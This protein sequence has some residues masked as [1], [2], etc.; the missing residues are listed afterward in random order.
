MKIF[1]R[2]QNILLL[3]VIILGFANT[4]S[5]ASFNINVSQDTFKIG[6]QFNVDIKID[7]EDVGINAGQATIKFSPAVLEVVSVDKTSSVFNF[8]IQDVK[9]DNTL[10]EVSFIGGSSSGLI[11]KTLQVVRLVVKAKGLGQSDFVFTDGA[12]TASDGSGTNVLSAMNKATVTIASTSATG[13]TVQ[14]IERTPIT[15]DTVPAKP[16][17]SIPLY[18]DPSKWYNVSSKFTASWKL[19]STV[20]AVATLLNKNS[21]YDPTVSEGIYENESFSAISDGVWY[22]HVRFYNN[23]GWSTT[24]HYRIAIDT[25][26]PSAFVVDFADG[27]TTSDNPTP[28]I[29]YKAGDQLSGISLYHIQVDSDAVI[30][31]DLETSTLPA[32]IPG[33]HT[34]KVTAEDKAGNKVESSAQFEILPIESP[35]IF[36]ASS[37]VYVGEGELVVNGTSLAN[38]SIILDIKDQKG[39]LMY[40][41]ASRADDNGSWAMKIDSPLKKGTYYIEASSMDSRGALS[42]PVKSDIVS[43]VERPIMVIWGFNITYLELIIFLLLIVIIGYTVGWYSRKMISG[44]RSRK[45]L[46]SQRDV[47]SSFN[48]LKKDIEKIIKSWDDGKVEEHE[49]TEIEFNLRHISENLE[50]LQKYIISGIKDIDQK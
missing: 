5:A 43:V 38:V 19:P 42:L 16:V 32:Q 9:Y 25:V 24:N 11:G 23:M 49:I 48:I 27:L 31:T 6:D 21:A 45:I 30:D 14:T 17:V 2:K 35:K 36:S 34:V 33:Q 3:A 20:N 10:G 50:K 39:N 46:I 13:S 18:P 12:I 1:L 4:V 41:F 15:S 28:T 47:A 37:K 7:S 26:P 29:N 8:W 44:K 22:L 40:S